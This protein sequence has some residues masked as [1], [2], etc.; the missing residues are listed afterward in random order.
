MVVTVKHQ[1]GTGAGAQVLQSRAIAQVSFFTVADHE[2]RMMDENHALAAPHLGRGQERFQ[3]NQLA[4]SD[5]SP[6]AGVAGGNAGAGTYQCH[7]AAQTH[8]GIGGVVRAQFSRLIEGKH[9]LE[10]AVAHHLG[11]IG[12]VITGNHGHPIRRKFRG[13]NPAQG[14][15]PLGFKCDI[16][17]IAGES[18]MVHAS[19]RQILEQ[20]LQQLLALTRALL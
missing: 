14:R 1:I 16:A 17:H 3:A 15:V 5:P 8:E 18:E 7:I 9:A 2:W 13:C 19:R 6:G 4:F 10:Q 20:R 12:V 11:N